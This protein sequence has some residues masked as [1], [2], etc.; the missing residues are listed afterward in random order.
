MEAKHVKMGLAYCQHTNNYK[1]NNFFWVSQKHFTHLVGCAIEN[2]RVT[3][4]IELL[5]CQSKVQMRKFCLVQSF[6]N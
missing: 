1:T 3:F 6:I 2:I 4:K 5:I